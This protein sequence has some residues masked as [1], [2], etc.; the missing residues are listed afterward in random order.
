[1]HRFTTLYS[2]TALLLITSLITPSLAIAQE[3]ETDGSE[4]SGDSP[5]ES[6]PGPGMGSGESGYAGGSTGDSPSEGGPGPGAGGADAEATNQAAADAE[7]AAGYGMTGDVD[8]NATADARMSGT[9]DNDQVAMSDGTVQ[10]LSAGAAAADAISDA[11]LIGGGDTVDNAATHAGYQDGSVAPGEVVGNL[12]GAIGPAADVV[13][14]EIAASV[15]KSVV[16]NLST[17]LTQSTVPASNI[18]NVFSNMGINAVNNT[19]AALNAAAYAATEVIGIKGAYAGTEETAEIA[20]HTKTMTVANTPVNQ[21]KVAELTKLGTELG[22]QINA[23]YDD[24]TLSAAELDA[25]ISGYE[26]TYED[27]KTSSF[28]PDAANYH[29]VAVEGTKTGTTAGNGT[30]DKADTKSDTAGSEDD[31]KETAT[32]KTPNDVPSYSD[33][34]NNKQGADDSNDSTETTETK[35]QNNSYSYDPKTKSFTGAQDGKTVDAKSVPNSTTV[36]RIAKEAEPHSAVSINT[37]TNTVSVLNTKTGNKKSYDGTTGNEIPNAGNPSL[38]GK[39]SSFTKADLGKFKSTQTIQSTPS[40]DLATGKTDIGDAPDSLKEKAEKAGFELNDSKTITALAIAYEIDA[41]T[42]A[43]IVSAYKNDPSFKTL[44]DED[45][46]EAAGMLNAIAGEASRTNRSIAQQIAHPNYL[47]SVTVDEKAFTEM[48]KEDSREA[49]SA[50]TEKLT[51]G[52]IAK[53]RGLS[54]AAP[55]IKANHFYASFAE[56]SIDWADDLSASVEVGQYNKT[57]I[58][59]IKSEINPEKESVENTTARSANLLTK[60]PIENVNDFKISTLTPTENLLKANLEDAANKTAPTYSDDAEKVSSDTSDLVVQKQDTTAKHRK[61]DITGTLEKQLAYASK[62]TG[63]TFV[64]TSGGQASK[65][66]IRQGLAKL[67]ERTGSNRHDHGNAADGYLV[68]ENGH[69]LNMNNAEDQAKM[70]EF[71]Q[72]AV[73]AGVTG[74]GAGNGYMGPYTMHLGGGSVSA[75]GAGGESANAPGWVKDALAD[76][77]EEA[78][79]FNK[80]ELDNYSPS[81]TD[82][83]DEEDGA[84]NNNDDG[85]GRDDTNSDDSNDTEDERD[86][87]NDGDDNDSDSDTDGDNG[88][89]AETVHAKTKEAIQTGLKNLGIDVS[90]QVASLMADAAI[91]STLSTVLPMPLAILVSILAKHVKVSDLPTG[92]PPKDDGDGEQQTCRPTL[93]DPCPETQGATVGLVMTNVAVLRNLEILVEKIIGI[94]QET[95][96]IEP[97]DLTSFPEYAEV[98]IVV[99]AKNKEIT[100][101]RHDL[102][103]EAVADKDSYA[104][105]ELDGVLEMFEEPALLFGDD[106]NIVYSNGL[107]S[108]LVENGVVI[109]SA[110]DAIYTYVVEYIDANGN[111]VQLENNDA[112]LPEN[113][114]TGMTRG[115]FTDSSTFTVVDV[116][117]ITYDLVDPDSEVASDEYYDYLITLKDGTIRTVLVPQYTSVSYMQEKFGGVGFFGDVIGLVSTSTNLPRDPADQGLVGRLVDGIK[118]TVATFISPFSPERTGDGPLGTIIDLPTY[119]TGLSVDDVESVYIYPNAPVPCPLIGG[120]SDGYVFIAVLNDR[121]D[122]NKVTTITSALCGEG[123]AP[124][125]VSETANN[126]ATD[127]GI[128]GASY[129]TLADKTYFRTEAITFDAGIETLNVTT[130]TEVISTSTEGL[131]EDVPEDTVFVPNVS[132][133]VVLEVKAVGADGKILSDWSA[134]TSINISSSVSLYFRWDGSAYQQCLPFLQDAGNYALTR[135]DKAMLKGDTESEGFNV[136]ERT[137]SY[138]VECGGQR[139]NEFGVDERVVE[140]TVQ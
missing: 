24:K 26:K 69:K 38:P 139:N 31:S 53:E 113:I 122:Q 22:Q 28:G 44:S 118:N 90:D 29:N 61:R 27:K 91:S 99:D 19:K 9:I 129:E 81:N 85:T 72:A 57:T 138:R 79:T 124:T 125:L 83:D 121:T 97:E 130:E 21:A 119:P 104:G 55:A 35:T 95:P 100:L 105:D 96:V 98:T 116:A 2:L 1:M 39:A 46:S 8:V 5:S 48:S 71:M 128:T 12:T 25:K 135:K 66:D 20:I 14:A 94:D 59:Y 127:F 49:L 4:A 109:D 54:V 30:T 102:I 51:D 41:K 33:M 117:T 84:N 60:T 11:A 115:I 107:Y 92:T 89:D 137:A 87:N 82:G 78:K 62:V 108:P 70:K 123:D 17:G 74:I 111:K 64:V 58:G 101:A 10:S 132:N 32:A 56:D 110:T 77:L 67:S 103:D 13:R 50:L 93:E 45:I 76:G 63:L 52:T 134:A 40:T 6:G 88:N 73:R 65:A 80:D 47:S 106:G 131:P 34:M 16:N 37:K 120:Y 3:G 36:D 133:D 136:P 75:W 86:N 15:T 23:A 112:S 140:V 18:A 42:R 43:N 114:L 126:L 7:T 68:D